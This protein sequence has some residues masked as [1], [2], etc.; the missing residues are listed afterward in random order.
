MLLGRYFCLS[1][2]LCLL[3]VLDLD[4][5]LGRDYHL[6]WCEWLICFWGLAMTDLVAV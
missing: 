5:A 1:H 6:I 3:L 2:G 4:R